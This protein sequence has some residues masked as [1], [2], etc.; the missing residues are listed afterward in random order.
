MFGGHEIANVHTEAIIG[1]NGH[2]YAVCPAL[3]CNREATI[4]NLKKRLASVIN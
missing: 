4:L 2:V 1:L 3:K